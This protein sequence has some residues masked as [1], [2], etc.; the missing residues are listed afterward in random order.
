MSVSLGVKAY[1]GKNSKEFQKHFKAVLFCHE[2]QLSYPKETSDFFKGKVDG[3]DLEDI[4]TDY[5][6]D[7]IK[8]GVQVP[9]RVNHVGG[10]GNELRISISDIPKEVD[11]LV[12]KLS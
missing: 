11:E 5:I 8:D 2:N 12:I 9:L 7:Y 10:S 1:S 6:I 3:N 4:G